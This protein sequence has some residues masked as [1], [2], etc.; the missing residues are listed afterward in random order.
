MLQTP[1]TQEW[2]VCKKKSREDVCIYTQKIQT[3]VSM[4]Y[5]LYEGLNLGTET[6][7]DLLFYLQERTGNKNL[8]V[9]N[10]FKMTEWKFISEAY[11]SDILFILRQKL[12]FRDSSILPS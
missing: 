1:K 5:S 11:T 3:T 12:N 9:I 2:V 4:S 6:F 8:H 10:T 7:I